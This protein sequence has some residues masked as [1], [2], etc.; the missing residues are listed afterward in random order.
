M[1][2]VNSKKICR[3]C[4]VKSKKKLSES[5]DTDEYSFIQKFAMYPFKLHKQK[6]VKCLTSVDMGK[7]NANRFIFYYSAMESKLENC[8]TIPK[9]KDAY[10][11]VSNRGLS[12][13]DKDGKANL[14]LK[15]PSNYNKNNKT[16]ISHIHFLVTDKTNKNWNKKIYT[17]RVICHIDKSHLKK[18]IYND[19]ALIINALP[20]E[21]YIKNH[22]PK[23][24]PLPYNLNLTDKQIVNYIKEMLVH[25][26]KIKMALKKGLSIYDIPIV[27]YCY[28]PTCNASS[29]LNDKLLKIGFTNIVEYSGGIT[30]WMKK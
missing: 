7:S 16:Y 18:I 9:F 3:S 20:M 26:T 24:I 4:K 8:V 15:C 27:T 29:L 10:K 23:S 11:D 12:K 25:S 21:E 6:D 30:D 1:K 22:I 13:L 19:C 5:N 17:K 2:K 28:K 14:Y